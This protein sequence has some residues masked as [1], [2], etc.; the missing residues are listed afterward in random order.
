LA[1]NDKAIWDN[2]DQRHGYTEGPGTI[3]L[4]HITMR[5][6]L[7]FLGIAS[8][9]WSVEVLP[10]FWNQS[11]IE[12]VATRVLS[13]NL[14][15]AE[16][17]ADLAPSLE[18]IELED[19]CRPSAMRSAAI[20]RLRLAEQALAEIDDNTVQ[21][22]L[23][24]ARGSIGRSL[25]CNPDDPFLWMA[26]YWV[27]NV[28]DGFKSKNLDFIRLSYQL[29]PNEG[30]IAIKRNRL[31]LV[32]FRSLP[33]DIAKMAIREFRL[34]LKS[35]FYSPSAVTLA[36]LGTLERNILLS[37]LRD[38]PQR[39]RDTLSKTLYRLG[40]DIPIPGTRAPDRRPW[41]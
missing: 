1:A 5:I 13:G 6:I 23:A 12:H 22:T 3:N 9:V 18:A 33:P 2:L 32:I 28:W 36:A 24:A 7:I 39:D 31:S 26:L 34:L 37:H 11:A 30:W 20:I 17:M 21:G 10:L 4:R 41:D 19:S 29:G 38:V 27:D 14:F 8:A 35:G 16:V 15:R 40:Y 25:A